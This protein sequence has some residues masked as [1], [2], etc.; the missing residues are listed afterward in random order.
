MEKAYTLLR[1]LADEQP[2]SPRVNSVLALIQLRRGQH[3]EA[4]AY[5]ESVLQ[6]AKTAAEK[7]MAN[8]LLSRGYLANDDM[9]AA[10]QYFGK[11]IALN[12]AQELELVVDD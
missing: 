7:K 3:D 12:E 9:V 2:N 6:H 4:L 5:A 11:F 1:L 10:K 8:Y